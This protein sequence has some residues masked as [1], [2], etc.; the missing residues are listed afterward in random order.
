MR[1]PMSAARKK[2]AKEAATYERSYTAAKSAFVQLVEGG[3]HPHDYAMGYAVTPHGIV[4]IY[5][6]YE[7]ASLQLVMN[8]RVYARTEFRTM[9][10]RALAIACTKFARRVVGATS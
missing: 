4:A 1:E 7:Y 5:T 2:V 9:S 6:Q 8:G 3:T 10:R